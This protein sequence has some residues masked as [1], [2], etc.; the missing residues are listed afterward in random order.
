MKIDEFLE[1]ANLL[2][3]PQAYADKLNELKAYEESIKQNIQLGIDITNIE[4]IKAETNQA[5]DRAKQLVEDAQAK[6]DAIISDAKTQIDQAIS[7]I[8]DQQAKLND[9]AIAQKEKEDHLLV[10]ST[11]LAAEEQL[12]AGKKQEL[13]ALIATNLDKQTDLDARIEKLKSVMG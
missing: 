2:A 5:L 12:V 1:V 6:A 7:N 10:R 9:Q 4:S 3:N 8:N 13:D 11:Q